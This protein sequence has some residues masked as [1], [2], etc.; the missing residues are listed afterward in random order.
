METT[1]KKSSFMISDIL[2][3]NDHQDDNSST[4]NE[5]DDRPALRESNNA[6]HVPLY[7]PSST[8]LPSSSSLY[9][10]Q[11]LHRPDSEDSRNDFLDHCSPPYSISAYDVKVDGNNDQETDESNTES[12]SQNSTGESKPIMC[13]PR[14]P[15][16]FLFAFHF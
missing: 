4:N 14:L 2:G 9:P 5:E 3:H 6:D 16:V 15:R 7:Q 13:D 10:Q 12:L 1:R 8:L 11:V